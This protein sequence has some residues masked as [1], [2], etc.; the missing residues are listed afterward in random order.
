MENI[1]TKI[2]GK[3]DG[4]ILNTGETLFNSTVIQVSNVVYIMLSMLII[5]I[6]LNTSLNIYRMSMRDSMQ[7]I[8][9]IVLV[10]IVGLSWN[11]FSQIFDALTNATQGLALSFFAPFTA[12]A[13]G[14]ATQALDRFGDQMA[15]TTDHVAQAV[16]SFFRA[17]VAFFLNVMLAV[18]MAAYVIVVGASK[19]VIAFLIGFAPFAMIC[20]IF[21]KT[22]TIF[23]GWLT[24][25]V[26]NL[27]Y[28]VVAAGIV[29][30]VVSVAA[31]IFKPGTPSSILGDFMAFIVL[32]I[33]G[34]MAILKIPSIAHGLTG[35]FGVGGFA[36]KPLNAVSAAI[37]GAAGAT[38]AGRKM[39]NKLDTMRETMRSGALRAD[40]ADYD[41]LSRDDRKTL[42]RTEELRAKGQE[43]MRKIQ[44]QA[45]MR[46]EFRGK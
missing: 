30:T 34:A 39:S 31:T 8:F 15:Q 24:T 11:N 10:L 43:M 18:L 21:E 4:V 37:G 35:S 12:D 20:T 5:L 14:T 29:G 28:P 2:L 7:I 9:R 3:I 22:K 33:A 23:E 6:G 41:G 36:P 38:Y 26:A 32:M 27:L 45:K 46:D 16:S 42:D 17:L 44:M 40:H 25:L 1:V 13:G 19:I